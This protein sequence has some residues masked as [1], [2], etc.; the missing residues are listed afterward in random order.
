M[1]S[2]AK[3]IEIGFV[4]GIPTTPVYPPVRSIQLPA[5]IETMTPKQRV[6]MAK[7]AP[8]VRRVG[9]PI[10]SPTNA[11]IR[12]DRGRAHQKERPLFAMRATP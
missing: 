11:V 9:S 12:A 2:P 8:R 3:G 1:I 10:R 4:R 6:T 5:T 7:Y